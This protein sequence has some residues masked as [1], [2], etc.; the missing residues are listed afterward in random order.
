LFSPVQGELVEENIAFIFS[1]ATTEE[2][3]QNAFNNQ[4]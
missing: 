3:E 2:I 4:G 1:E